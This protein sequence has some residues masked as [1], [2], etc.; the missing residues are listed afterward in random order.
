MKIA[1]RDE[2]SDVL[3]K[4]YNQKLLFVWTFNLKFIFSFLILL[5]FSL[6][7]WSKVFRAHDTSKRKKR[8]QI[9]IWSEMWNKI[10]EYKKSFIEL[11]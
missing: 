6:Q 5:F 1:F 4:Q 10:E 9:Q 11:N 8:R 3:L 2:N 7:M